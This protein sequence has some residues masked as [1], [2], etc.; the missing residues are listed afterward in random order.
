[1]K[2]LKAYIAKGDNQLGE[3]V[4]I[5]VLAR[6]IWE[7]YRIFTKAANPDEDSPLD[8]QYIL[9]DVILVRRRNGAEF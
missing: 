3:R 4:S 9:R 7:I 8:R 5:P 2:A 1:M 6:Y